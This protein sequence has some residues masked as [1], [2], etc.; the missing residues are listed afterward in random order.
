MSGV[1]LETEW[2]ATDWLKLNAAVGYLDHEYDRLAPEAAAQGITLDSMIPNA[3]RNGRSTPAAP[4]NLYDGDRGRVFLLADYTYRSEMAKDPANTPEITED[5]YSLVN[6]SLNYQSAD[7][8]WLLSAGA[9]NLTDEAYIVTGVF[10][11]GRWDQHGRAEPPARMV[12]DAAFRI[13]SL[14]ETRP[15]TPQS[16]IQRWPIPAIRPG[17]LLPHWTGCTSHGA[18]RTSMACSR[19]SRKTVSTRI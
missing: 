14:R 16:A 15:I 12:R 19:A 1:E 7:S 2:A 17:P 5:G 4:S 10:N 13:L 18:G 6:A 3:R 11:S 9:R 8:R